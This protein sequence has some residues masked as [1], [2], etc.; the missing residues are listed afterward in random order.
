VAILM[1][2]KLPGATTEQYDRVTALLGVAEALPAGL[3]SHM[4][5]ATEEDGLLIVDVWQ[6]AEDFQAFAETRLRTA[7]EQAGVPQSP[8]P[9]IL[10]VHSLIRQGAGRDA[11]VMF[12]VDLPNFSAADYDE[13]VGPMPE[14]QG[15]GSTHPAVSHVAALRDGGGLFVVDVWDSPESAMAFL[16]TVDPASREKIGPMEPRFVPIHNRLVA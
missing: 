4:A 16:G 6:S 5:G 8:H 11:R 3:I 2:Q 13:V 10:P 9:Q 12:V 14:H 15:G 7:T 1:V